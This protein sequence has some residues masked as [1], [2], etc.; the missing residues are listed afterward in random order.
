[1]I[2]VFVINQISRIPIFIVKNNENNTMY[3]MPELLLH[4]AELM[5][6]KL[7]SSI[8]LLHSSTNILQFS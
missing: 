4:F 2:H 8:F 6:I 3:N 7:V 1:M 5:L